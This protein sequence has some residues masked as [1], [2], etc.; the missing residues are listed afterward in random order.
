MNLT[1]LRALIRS[2]NWTPP[3]PDRIGRKRHHSISLI[4]RFNDISTFMGYIIPKSSLWKN[5]WYFSLLAGTTEY[6][7]L[8]LCR[9]ASPPLLMN[10][11]DMTLTIWWYPSLPLFPGRPWPGVVIPV[12]VP[13]MGKIELFNHL[14]YLKPFNCANRWLILNKIISVR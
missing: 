3:Q 4:S 2:L 9:G 11:L 1:S 12:R 8:H 10:V 6:T 7:W 14:L 13:S 5:K